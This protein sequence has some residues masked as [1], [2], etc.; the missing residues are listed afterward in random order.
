MM[1]VQFAGIY[2]VR[3]CADAQPPLLRSVSSS[4]RICWSIV[5]WRSGNAHIVTNTPH[6]ASLYLIHILKTSLQIYQTMLPR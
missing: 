2:R 5:G 4:S 3:C 6:Q 1:Y